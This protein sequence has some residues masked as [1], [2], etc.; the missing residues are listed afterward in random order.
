LFQ[1]IILSMFMILLVL[2]TTHPA[3]AWVVCSAT[4]HRYTQ[5]VPLKRPIVRCK[6]CKPIETFYPQIGRSLCVSE[7]QNIPNVQK[8]LP[9]IQY[10]FQPSLVKNKSIKQH[11]LCFRRLVW[12]Q[13]L[14][15][16]FTVNV[17]FKFA[18]LPLYCL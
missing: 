15:R 8:D 12:I 1:A 9:T 3:F 4:Q 14:I 17:T 6:L 16:R 18:F 2:L 10:L 13:T 5:R 7:N 11:C